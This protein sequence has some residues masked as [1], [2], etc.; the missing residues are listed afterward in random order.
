M[1]IQCMGESAEKSTYQFKKQI[2]QSAHSLVYRAVRAT[3]GQAVILKVLKGNHPT[4]E[5]LTRYRQEYELTSSL[6]DLDGVVNTYS[7]ERYH[8]SLAM[9]LEDFGGDSLAILSS[10]GRSFTLD[11]LLTFAIHTTEILGQIHRLNI[12][13]KD[14]NPSNIIVNLDT[15]DL[16]IIDF[17]ISTRF[18]NQYPMVKH[19]DVLEGTLAYMSPE[20]TGRMNR[21]LDYRTDFYSLG[22]TLYELFTGTVPFVSKDAMELVHCHIAKH[23]VPPHEIKSDLPLAISDIIIKLLEKTAETRYQSA[24]GIKTDLEFCKV[25]L[26]DNRIISPFTL[27][28]KDISDRFHIPQKLYG[29]DREIETLLAASERVTSGPAE[30]IMVAGSPGIGKSVLIKE[31]HR[32]LVEKRGYFIEGK[33]DQYQRNIPYSG[34]VAAFRELVRQLLA[35][36]VKQLSGWKEKILAALGSNGQVVIDVLPEIELIIGP[37]PAV[38]QLAPRESQNRFNIVFKNFVQA[39]CQPGH[40]LV[41]FLDDLQ[42]GDSGTLKLL[43]LLATDSE[44]TALLTIGAYRDNEV[45]PTHPLLMMLDQLREKPVT[46]HQITL[47]PLAFEH[48]NQL[49]A[50]C[51]RQSIEAV[52]PLTKLVMRKTDGNPFFVNQFLRTLYEEGLLHFVPSRRKQEGHWQWDLKQIESIPIADNVVDLMT[53]KLRKLPESTQQVLSLAACIGNRFDL[54]ILSLIHEKPEKETFQ[55][56]MP[57]LA[58]DLILPLAEQKIA[59][60]DILHSPL[61]IGY[62]QFLHDRIQQAAYD[63]IDHEQKKYLRLNIGRLLLKKCS[64]EQVDE[65]LFSIVEHLN[66]GRTYLD[67]QE[68]RDGLSRLNLRAGQKAR[69]AAAYEA[70]FGYLRTGLECLAEMSWEKNY[71]LTLCLHETAIETAYMANELS[72]MDKLSSAVFHHARAL[73]DTTGTYDAIIHT[74]TMMSNY[75]Q[76]IESGSEFLKQLKEELPDHPTPLEIQTALAN[77]VAVLRRHSIEEMLNLPEMTDPYRLAELQI[78]NRLIPA[79][80]FS[81]PS[82]MPFL[83]ERVIK[84]S[85]EYGI[86]PM[87]PFGYGIFGII[88]SGPAV[89]DFENAYYACQLAS[90]L[91]EKQP[92]HPQRGSVFNSIYGFVNHWMEPIKNSFAP[93]KEGYLAALEAGDL[94]FAGYISSNY[95]RNLYASGNRLSRVREEFDLYTRAMKNM[96]QIPSLDS[97]LSLYQTILNLLERTET[98]TVLDG[99]VFREREVERF[100]RESS[101]APLFIYYFSKLHLCLLF[102]DYEK[103]IEFGDQ[104]HRYVMQL[105]GLNPI[106]HFY[107][108]DTLLRII[109]SGNAGIKDERIKEGYSRIKKW[110]EN[111]PMNYRHMRCLVEAEIAHR[112]GQTE[113]AMTLYEKAVSSARENEFLQDEALSYELAGRFYLKQGIAS[114]ARFNIEEAVFCYRLWGALAKAKDL[115]QRYSQVLIPSHPIKTNHTISDSSTTFKTGQDSLDLNTVVKVS[116]ALSGEIVLNRLLKNIIHIVIENAGAEKGFLIMPRNDRW[117]IE[118]YGDLDHSKTRL[119]H[120][121]PFEESGEVSESIIR[122]VARTRDHVILKNAAQEGDFTRDAYIMKNRPKSVLCAPLVNQRRLTG[123]LYLENNLASGAF[124]PKRVEILN[125]IST[126]IAISLE[127]SQLYE[128]LEQKVVERTAE[129]ATANEKLMREIKDR[130][131]AEEQINASLTEKEILLREL[132]HRVKNNLAVVISLLNLQA[133]QIKED[134]IAE[135]LKESRD[136]VMSIALIHETLYRSERLSEVKLIDYVK[137][138]SNRLAKAM[139]AKGTQVRIIY[140][141]E[142]VRL[143]IDQAIPCGLILN[144]LLTNALKYSPRNGQCQILIKAYTTALKEIELIVHDNGKGFPAGF[145]FSDI[146]SLGLRI[147]SDIIGN[148][149]EGVVEARNEN[150]ARITVRWPADINK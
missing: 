105:G 136:R 36:P 64:S 29:R 68:E 47:K 46:L 5:E 2:Y 99:E 53:K 124:T 23:P 21:A 132:H 15:G 102:G 73:L 143:T 50:D 144:E 113:K 67:A 71:E 52:S 115:E 100:I 16:K 134:R 83:C 57:V 34:I 51:L 30:I 78:V 9:C 86:H 81:N 90:K 55:E 98:P 41:I 4:S 40:P 94:E 10:G 22:A 103:G 74:N 125:I 43:E 93:M 49:I 131:Q 130:M 7:L 12:I 13:H 1:N 20:Q 110:A 126:Q 54:D 121:M 114:I 26:H 75:Q 85:V 101:I 62:M 87:T 70:A 35:E 129:L 77:I 39:F 97:T 119:L 148:Q 88:A 60:D 38:P 106:P 120:S 66:N 140:E 59:G 82:L 139:K 138:L 37:Q 42:W 111:A 24:W 11:E 95:L 123:I 141:I 69:R 32:A 56:L 133:N 48:T 18:S 19:P 108:Y 28:Q 92:N 109:Q 79:A 149:L 44:N 14:I 137:N 117:C 63:L 104:G 33:F 84:R 27:A 25:A 45:D 128:T 96:K 122:Y 72:L 6:A 91:L 76:A 127:N 150:G 118:A 112:S 80:F 135:A 116:Q 61:T 142:E 145:K 31:I 58:E 147:V 107:F 146:K 89:G 65:L 3:D 8:N 17:G